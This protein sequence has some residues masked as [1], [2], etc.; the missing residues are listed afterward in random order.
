MTC[1]LAVGL[2]NKLEAGVSNRSEFADQI[3]EIEIV[4]TLSALLHKVTSRVHAVFDV[5][6]A[7]RFE[8]D[9]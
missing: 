1:H 6:F 5:Q 7:I 2:T 4:C 9:Y 3:V 8:A